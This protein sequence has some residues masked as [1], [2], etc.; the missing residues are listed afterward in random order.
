VYYCIKRETMKLLILGIFLIINAL[1]FAIYWA[2]GD[3]AHKAWVIP[4]CIVCVIVGMFFTLHDRAI[5]VTFKGI[6]NIK[7]AEKQA[8]TDAEVI[9]NIK[10]KIEQQEKITTE[11][12]GAIE[13]SAIQISQA[14]DEV[15]LMQSQLQETQTKVAKLDKESKRNSQTSI[16]PKLVYSTHSVNKV[17]DGIEVLLVFQSS[18]NIALGKVEFSLDLKGETN[19]KFL[20][21]LPSESVS[22]AVMSKITENNR[23]A[24]LSY[25]TTSP[26]SPRIK[27]KISAP[28]SLIIQGNPGLEPF[29]LDIK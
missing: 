2:T 22:L 15:R 16:Q 10:N 13:K 19:S 8:T 27:V 14:L 6:G 20:S 26:S 4:L 11:L 3:N 12:Q 23:K 28:A 24:Q 25:I 1:A 9:S 21:I 29:E 5:E 7:A 18:G 17:S